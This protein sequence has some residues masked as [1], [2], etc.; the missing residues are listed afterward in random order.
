MTISTDNWAALIDDL[1][2]NRGPTS[3]NLAEQQLNIAG[4]L[5]DLCA[6]LKTNHTLRTLIFGNTTLNSAEADTLAKMVQENHTITEIYLPSDTVI[7]SSLEII[8]VAILRNRALWGFKEAQAAIEWRDR[9]AQYQL[10]ICYLYGIR[11]PKDYKEALYWLEKAADNGH[12]QAQ[13]MLGSLLLEGKEDDKR[14]FYWLKKAAQNGDTDS[15]CNLG[16]CLQDSVG[17]ERNDMEAFYWFESAAKQKHAEAQDNVGCCLLVGKGCQTDEA[18]AFHW[19]AKAARRG[20]GE[21]QYHL[22]CCLMAEIGRP[23][24]YM[25]DQQ[26]TDAMQIMLGICQYKGIGSEPSRE[27]ALEYFREAA[28]QENFIAKFI[29]EYMEGRVRA[30]SLPNLIIEAVKKLGHQALFQMGMFLDKIV[31]D[32]TLAAQVMRLAADRGDPFAQACL[33]KHSSQD[34]AIM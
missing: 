11:V 29:L 16:Y 24:A 31:G 30:E 5:D 33:A 10:S 21:A 34:C 2:A 28:A 13:S 9:E 14:A 17:C 25:I 6:A 20:Y 19:F 26:H 22:I 3:L 32:Q 18:A 4:H 1:K 15:Q 27:L 8:K 7:D 12:V 23:G